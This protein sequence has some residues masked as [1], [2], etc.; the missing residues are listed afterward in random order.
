MIGVCFQLLISFEKAFC[1][2]EYADKLGAISA[3]TQFG[4]SRGN[5]QVSRNIVARG[6]YVSF[7]VRVARGSFE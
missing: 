7:L 5:S 3:N 2:E 1:F 4:I 6:A